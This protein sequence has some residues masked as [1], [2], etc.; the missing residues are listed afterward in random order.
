MQ[1]IN[2]EE[3][4]QE[5]R[6]EIKEKGY[7]KDMLSFKDVVS[8]VSTALPVEFDIVE[9]RE[10]I[11]RMNETFD[12]P[13]YRDVGGGI[14]GFIKKVIRKLNMFLIAPVTED[15]S[16]FNSR[17]VNSSNQVL[18]FIE[19]QNE[20]MEELKEEIRVLKAELQKAKGT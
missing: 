5:I 19:E 12:I 14:K 10:V 18:C 7:T 6:A 3:I 13:W 8:D 15:Q 9:L 17:V 20:K 2:V 16:E 11:E 4:M 1:E